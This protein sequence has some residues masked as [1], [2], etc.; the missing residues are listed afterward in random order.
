MLDIVCDAM[1]DNDKICVFIDGWMD[2]WIR[3]SDAI[4]DLFGSEGVEKKVLSSEV[5]HTSNI[6]GAVCSLHT[7]QIDRGMTWEAAF[8]RLSVYSAQDLVPD[9]DSSSSSQHVDH[10]GFYESK[11]EVPGRRSKGL[12][13]AMKRRGDERSYIIAVRIKHTL[14]AHTPDF[15][16]CP[17]SLHW[18]ANQIRHS[19]VPTLVCL[20]L[21]WMFQTCSTSTASRR[22][23]RQRI[24]GSRCTARA[25]IGTGPRQTPIPLPFSAEL[26]PFSDR[27]PRS[28]PPRFRLSC[29]ATADRALDADA[30]LALLPGRTIPLLA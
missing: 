15:V 13:L 16:F 20:V 8:E 10:S 18:D 21:R 26:P 14:G 23:K 3:Y 30:W 22:P 29:P 12:L 4:T 9:G 27:P 25:S 24:I 19:S 1:N 17:L 28:T 2:G 5:V 6:T 11:R 7:I